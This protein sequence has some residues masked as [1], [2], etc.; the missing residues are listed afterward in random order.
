[1]ADGSPKRLAP[2]QRKAAILSAAISLLERNGLK[3]FSLGAV[4]REAGVAL[5]L[6]RHY[7]GSSRDLLKAAIEDLLVEVEATLLGRDF[8]G[9]L[10]ERF[11]AYLDLLAKNPWGH[12]VWM[13][14]AEIH[15]KVEG[16]VHEARLRM[17]ETM[18]RRPWRE[19]TKMEQLDARGRIGYIETVVAEWL[20]HGAG[21]KAAVL[22]L[23]VRAGTMPARSMSEQPEI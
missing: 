4:A 19:L 6:P 5:S 2:D 23:L 20:K 3:G 13:R 9:G 8:K 10:A 12:D 17:A 1:M 18:W 22:E 7:F 16:V 21:D 15:P 11:A 14:A